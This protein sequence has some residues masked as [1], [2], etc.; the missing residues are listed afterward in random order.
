MDR[1]IANKD[2]ESPSKKKR[3]RPRKIDQAVSHSSK[4]A[5]SKASKDSTS[6]VPPNELAVTTNSIGDKQLLRTNVLVK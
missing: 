3:G 6:I 2:V 4:K 5:D 1:T